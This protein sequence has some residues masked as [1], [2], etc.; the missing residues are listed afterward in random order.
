MYFK[1]KPLALTKIINYLFQP[2]LHV[3][4]PIVINIMKKREPLDASL[5]C[6]SGPKLTNKSSALS[7]IAMFIVTSIFSNGFQS[8]RMSTP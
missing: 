3:H 6:G 7:E 1:I 5:S 4:C 2:M 8:A